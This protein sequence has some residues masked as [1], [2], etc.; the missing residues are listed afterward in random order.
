M[1]DEITCIFD[2][3]QECNGCMICTG[4]DITER[5]DYYDG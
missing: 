1:M 2:D 4:E 3:L 5:D